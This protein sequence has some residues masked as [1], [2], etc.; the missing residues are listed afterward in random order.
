MSHSDKNERILDDEFER[1][2]RVAKQTIEQRR[3]FI[4]ADKDDLS[5]ETSVEVYLA[6]A[7]LKYARSAEGPIMTASDFRLMSEAER[8]GCYAS[9]MRRALALNAEGLNAEQSQ[10]FLET[11][12]NPKPISPALAAGIAKMEKLASSHVEQKRCIT[13]EDVGYATAPSSVPFKN[14]PPSSTV[15]NTPTPD[16]DA[17]EQERW[18]AEER[19]SIAPPNPWERCRQMERERD[20]ARRQAFVA[21]CNSAPSHVEAN[22]VQVLP[23]PPQPETITTSTAAASAPFNVEAQRVPQGSVGAPVDAEKNR[24]Q[25]AAASAP[26][27]GFVCGC[28]DPSKCIICAPA[29]SIGTPE[30][31]EE[32]IRQLREQ[33]FAGPLALRAE[34]LIRDLAADR[35]MWLHDDVKQ[36][37]A[38][39]R[40]VAELEKARASATLAIGPNDVNKWAGL[41]VICNAEL[42]K[43][44]EAM[45]A[46][47]DGKDDA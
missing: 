44:L 47:T 19:G 5:P 28:A 1:M 10:H 21:H 39:G 26:K 43:K 32:V 6:T 15:P 14:T 29:S 38:L 40:C 3:R 45:M 23:L 20:Q 4:A 33:H 27:E 9:A 35:D 46:T 36:N 30:E 13:N 17:W 24:S 42:H 2:T 7:F 22:I 12:L 16:T 11:M 31:I 34:K 25:P 8:Y 37:S 18:R 41:L